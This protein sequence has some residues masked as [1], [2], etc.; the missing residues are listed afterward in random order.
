MADES[1]SPPLSDGEHPARELMDL[2]GRAHA[3]AILYYVT[4]REQRPWRFN[5]LEA[6]L[7]ISPNTLS[8]RLEE[9]TDAGL[10]TRRS[11]DE[12]P[13]RVEYEATTKAQE[14]NPIFKDLHAWAERH[15]PEAN[16]AFENE[17]Q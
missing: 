14:L 11:Y 8:N 6:E 1:R 7:D 9:L 4:R 3:L 16:E 17:E 5:E 2:L 13:P 12:I 10:L 15:W